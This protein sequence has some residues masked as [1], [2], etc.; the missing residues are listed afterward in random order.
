MDTSGLS[1]LQG[2]ALA[3]E[4]ETGVEKLA[5]DQKRIEGH[6]VVRLIEGAGHPQPPGPDP[7]A[8]VDPEGRG[9]RVNIKI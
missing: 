8:P 6:A 9:A 2:A 3:L 4:Y 1:G 5:Q 7:V